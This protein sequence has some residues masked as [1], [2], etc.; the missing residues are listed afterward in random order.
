MA[1]LNSYDLPIGWDAPDFKLPNTE[2]NGISPNNFQE[3]K[4]LLVV[5][6]CNHCPYAKASWPLVIDLFHKFSKDVGFLAVNPNDAITHPEDSYEIMKEKKIEWNI[7]FD[8]LHDAS[9]EIA[10]AYKAQCTPDLYLLKNTDGAWKLFYHGRIN[11]NWQDPTAVQEKNL[12]DV[13]AD[14]VGDKEPP[15][16]QKPSMGCSI[17]WKK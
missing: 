1:L 2:G 9:Q 6:T 7:P 13:L 14:L 8:Y 5:F 10:K 3:K 17:K 12:E 4:G 16:D 15:K 11:D